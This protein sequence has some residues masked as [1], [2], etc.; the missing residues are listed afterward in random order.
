M[1]LLVVLRAS[2][3][4]ENVINEQNDKKADD[5]RITYKYSHSVNKCLI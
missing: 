1:I 3:L 5:V 4:R 2:V